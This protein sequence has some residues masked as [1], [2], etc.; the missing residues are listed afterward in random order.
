MSPP[1]CAVASV[2]HAGVGVR[3]VHHHR[4]GHHVARRRGRFGERMA[5]VDELGHRLGEALPKVQ[6][7]RSFGVNVPSSITVLKSCDCACDCW[8]ASAKNI[9]I[10][11]WYA[12]SVIQPSTSVPSALGD[13]GDRVDLG[14]RRREA[15][16]QVLDLGHVRRHRQ[17]VERNPRAP[18]ARANAG[19]ITPAAGVA[20]PR[21]SSG[22]D[23]AARGRPD[24][25][26]ARAG[27]QRQGC[28][29][30]PPPRTASGA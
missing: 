26:R 18:G 3:V 6:Q 11:V 25:A 23:T 29:S 14:L 24:A 15:G 10:F 12:G 8:K 9:S 13:R 27:R 7:Q 16:E 30:R 5:L 2:E 19:G 4:R 21:A 1:L 17:R 22:P 20:D 28:Q